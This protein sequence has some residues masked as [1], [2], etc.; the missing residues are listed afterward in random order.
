MRSLKRGDARCELAG[1][2]RHALARALHANPARLRF[3]QREV[4]VLDACAARAT[5][6]P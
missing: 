2:R 3:V 5:G 6:A 1:V 4:E